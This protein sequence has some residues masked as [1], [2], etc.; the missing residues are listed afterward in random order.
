[1]LV[2]PGGAPRPESAPP[3]RPS[4]YGASPP[5]LREAGVRQDA[6]DSLKLEDQP[7][8]FSC[9]SVAGHWPPKAQ[10]FWGILG[11]QHFLVTTHLAAT[12]VA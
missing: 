7:R 12:V 2:Y 6:W 8:G 3:R 9:L 4:L 11:H 5:S 10:K 1:M